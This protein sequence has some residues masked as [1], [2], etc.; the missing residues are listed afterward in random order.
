MKI[1]ITNYHPGGG[2]G[3]TTYILALARNLHRFGIT[4]IVACPASS[5][6]YDFLVQ[7]GKV[8]VVANDFPNKIKEL[9][10]VVRSIR[11]IS[12]IIKEN[13]IDVIHVNGSPD[14]WLVSYYKTIFRSNIP[15]VR[16]RHGMQR[17]KDAW[18]TRFQNGLTSVTIAVCNAQ[19][20]IYGRQRAF[21]GHKIA[22]IPNGVDH[23]YFAPRPASIEVRKRYGINEGDVILGSTAGI[24]GHKGVP[25]FLSA[26]APIIREHPF[27]KV[28][29]VGDCR[30]GAYSGITGGL[31]ISDNVIL[32][33]FQKD[34]RDFVSVFDFGFVFSRAIETISY[35]VREMM[36]MGKPVIVS[37]FG[38]LP[39]NVIDGVDGFIIKARSSRALQEVLRMIAGDKGLAS[40]MGALAAEKAARE[41][42]FEDSLQKTADVYNSIERYAS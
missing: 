2:G 8:K 41:F 35:S 36:M 1:L 20:E 13:G 33:G 9:K 22:V 14:H 27:V 37:D 25:E 11:N 30:A 26:A 18:S 39:E 3:H 34:I 10:G 31:G 7:E 21:F 19:N 32:T 6:L 4:P 38:G 42:R 17:V 29:L 24:A 40:R 15:V 5:R 23:E 12:R 28:M 16:T